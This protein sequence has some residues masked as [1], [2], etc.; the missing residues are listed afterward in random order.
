MPRNIRISPIDPSS[1]L[2]KEI[3][4]EAR[5]EGYDF[6]DRLIEEAQSGENRFDKTGE[7]FYGAFINE[8]LVG[9]AGVNRDP[10]TDQE[11][12]RLRHVYVLRRCRR[13]GVASKLVRVLLNHSIIAFEIIRL[14]T[15]D[16]N[17]DKFYEALGFKKTVEE[18]ASHFIEI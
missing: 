4:I 17:A 9:C 12:G 10:Y 7:L 14:R 11:F 16:Q 6:V 3:A 15:S 18:G 1:K 2:L 8:T 13:I 5:D